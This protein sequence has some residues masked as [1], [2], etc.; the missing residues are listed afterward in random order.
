MPRDSF[1]ERELDR[2]ATLMQ[3]PATQKTPCHSATWCLSRQRWHTTLINLPPLP[4][5]PILLQ[6]W[7]QTPSSFTAPTNPSRRSF[8]IKLPK[9]RTVI[10]T[11]SKIP[12]QLSLIALVFWSYPLV[13]FLELF[14]CTALL[15]WDEIRAANLTILVLIWPCFKTE[16]NVAHW[17]LEISQKSRSALYYGIL[18]NRDNWQLDPS[19]GKMVWIWRIDRHVK[20]IT[21][22]PC[23][24]IFVY[25]KL[26]NTQIPH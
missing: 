19:I 22:L 18:P 25:C 21:Q 10:N 15:F 8:I 24:H 14:L 13:A 9:C 4:V 17:V 26:K 2:Y 20:P 1:R 16:N 5:A 7:T 12:C 6:Q 23:S 11:N 3:G